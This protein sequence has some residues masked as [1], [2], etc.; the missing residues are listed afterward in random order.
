MGIILI[1]GG[2]LLYRSYALYEEEKEFNVLKGHP[3]LWI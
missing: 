2:I 3:R 1:L